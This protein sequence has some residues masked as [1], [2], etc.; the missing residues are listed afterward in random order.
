MSKTRGEHG[1]G[2]EMKNQTALQLHMPHQRVL[3][4][5]ARRGMRDGTAQP[6][7]THEQTT[8]TF[9]LTIQNSSRNSG[10]FTNPFRK[11]VDT[12]YEEKQNQNPKK[13]N[14]KSLSEY[15]RGFA[16]RYWRSSESKPG[17]LPR[18]C[19]YCADASSCAAQSSRA[20]ACL[21]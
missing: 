3:Q 14:P 10:T 13:T 1:P 11:Q 15:S 16:T 6:V 8:D 21:L 4:I 5:T 20:A 2:A 7:S 12:S 9:S 17:N 19:N 18:V